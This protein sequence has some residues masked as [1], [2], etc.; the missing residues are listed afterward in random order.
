MARRRRVKGRWRYALGIP[1]VLCAGLFASV[2]D[3][4]LAAAG[5]GALVGLFIGIGIMSYP[6]LDRG[7]PADTDDMMH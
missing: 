4:I 2:A 5:T 1:T 6:D 3:N 7:G